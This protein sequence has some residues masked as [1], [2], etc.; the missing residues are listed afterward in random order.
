MLCGRFLLIIYYIYKYIN[1]KRFINY[2]LY[3]YK[4]INL[5]RF[6]RVQLVSNVVL[7]SA[8]SE[9]ISCSAHLNLPSAFEC[10]FSGGAGTFCLFPKPARHA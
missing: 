7:V 1:L 3:I 5:K 10:K 6:I 9:I 4:Y 8:I 2:L